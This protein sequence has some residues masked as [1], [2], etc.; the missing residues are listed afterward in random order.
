MSQNTASIAMEFSL[1]TLHHWF[2]ENLS[3]FLDI[4]E[5]ITSLFTLLTVWFG[6]GHQR[7]KLL[8]E[9]LIL[10]EAG[11][12]TLYRWGEPRGTSGITA[13]LQAVLLTHP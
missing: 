1:K 5:Q 2:S 10:T 6:Y 3:F 8:S 9:L 13:G 11:V 4:F 7:Q 12:S